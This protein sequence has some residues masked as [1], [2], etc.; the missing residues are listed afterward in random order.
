M[1]KEKSPVLETEL[2]SR[3][4]LRNP[5][6]ASRFIP[7]IAMKIPHPKAEKLGPKFDV[8]TYIDEPQ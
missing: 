7:R 6:E 4:R 1:F 5:R 3:T 2:A 8:H